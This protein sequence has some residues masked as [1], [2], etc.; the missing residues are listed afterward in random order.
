MS[1]GIELRGLSIFA[2]KILMQLGGISGCNSVSKAIHEYD[3]HRSVK[4][5]ETFSAGE[6]ESDKIKK[7]DPATLMLCL[8]LQ[9]FPKS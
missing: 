3:I 2:L 7:R 6:E 9:A 1:E 8:V 5:E 4:A